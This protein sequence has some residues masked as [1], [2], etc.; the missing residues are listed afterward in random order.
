MSPEKRFLRFS[1]SRRF[2]HWVMVVSFTVLAITGLVQRFSGAGISEFMIRIMGGIETTRIIHRVA[3]IILVLSTI[4]HF[5]TV[6]YGWIVERKPLSMLPGK[7]DFT[8]AWKSLRYNLGYEKEEPKQGFYTFDEKLEYWALVWG[9]LLMGVTGFFLWN[10]VFAA[11]ILPGDWIPA[12]KAA[13]GNEAVLAVMAVLIWHIYNVHIKHFNKSMFSGYMSKEEMEHYHALALE[14]EEYTPPSKDDLIYKRRRRRFIITYGLISVVLIV[15]L[16]YFTTFE[17]TALT[18]V[19]PISEI[20][21]VESYSPLEPTLAPTPTSPLEAAEIG[22]SWEDGFALL[23]DDNCG[24]CH[25]SSVAPAG[26]DLTTYETA[27][28]GGE[29]GPA[30]RPGAPGISLVVIWSARGD[31]P[32]QFTSQ[33]LAA[34]K[35][36]IDNGAP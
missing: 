23:F 26:L 17:E 9:T 21:D 4:V 25:N 10:P 2:E 24:V 28:A 13:H 14:Q 12:A 15:A 32:G 22:S 3:A 20:K 5:G 33:E 18:T 16:Y 35:A 29:S 7:E 11:K 36:W 27:V 8:A 34:I 6:F 1:L 30:I 31:H 19:P